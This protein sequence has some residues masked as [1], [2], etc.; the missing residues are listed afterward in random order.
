MRKY[1]F[2]VNPALLLGLFSN[3]RN[4]MTVERGIQGGPEKRIKKVFVDPRNGTISIMY[5]QAELVLTPGDIPSFVNPEFSLVSVPENIDN[6]V[7]QVQDIADLCVERLGAPRGQ[8]FDVVEFL[9]E[10]VAPYM[11]NRE[12]FVN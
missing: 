6:L 4:L 3:G 12:R 5:E 7:S 8:A 11:E 2:R 9:R 10:Q 1:I